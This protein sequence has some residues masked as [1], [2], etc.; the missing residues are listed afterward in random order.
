MGSGRRLIAALLA[1]A[2]AAATHAR[3]PQMR[4]QYAEPVTLAAGT[5]AI[6]FDAYGRRFNLELIN[7]DRVTS[8]LPAQRKARLSG[9]R[10]LRGALPDQPGSWVRLTAYAGR[11][12]GAI[13]DGKDFYVVTTLGGIAANLTTPIAAAPEQTVV[14]RLS[15][16]IDAFPRGTCPVSTV[17]DGV[18]P[19]DGLSQYRGMV[20]ELA[21]RQLESAPMPLQI[22]ISLIGD[23]PFQSKYTD[24][25]FE[26]L[27]R[28]NVIDGVYAEQVGLLILPTDLRLIASAQDPFTSTDPSG[29]LGQLSTFRNQDPISRARGI[30]HLMTG[31]IL[32]GD[33]VGI[34][35]LG[36]VCSAV[37]GISL[38]ESSGNPTRDGLIMSHELGHNFGAVH[39]GTGACASAGGN[40]IM[41]PSLNFSR[42]FSQC[43]LDT[44]RPVIQTAQCVTA[45]SYGDIEID[46]TGARFVVEFDSPL[47]VPYN[48]RSTGTLPA[49]D[50]KL[51]VTA[52]PN[53]TFVTASLPS[54]CVVAGDTATCD[55][56]TIPAGEERNLSLTL[57]PATMTLSTIE[58]R[59][60]ASNNPSTHNDRQ[61]RQVEIIPNAD[62]SLTLDRSTGSVLIGGSVDFTIVV[63]SLRSHATQNTV[64]QFY[65][66]GG[67]PMQIE[68]AT[69]SGATCTHDQISARCELGALDSGVTRTITIRAKATAVGSTTMTATVSASNDPYIYND[70]ASESL[71]TRPLRDLGFKDTTPSGTMQVGMPFEYQTTLYSN[72]S[73]PVDGVRV[74][75]NL[76]M[77]SSV[78]NTLEL[79]LPGATCTK[80]NFALWRCEQGTLAAV[81]T[82]S[83]SIKGMATEIGDYR[84]YLT[85]YGSSQDVTTN[86]IA[87]STLHVRYG[88]DASVQVNDIYGVETLDGAGWF[89][90]WSN[91]LQ[92]V[93]NAVLNLELPPQVRLTRFFTTASTATCEMTDAQ[94]IRCVYLIPPQTGYQ[95]VDFYF[96][97]DSPGTFQGKAT[98]TLEGD[99]APANNIDDFTF[100]ISP[101][102]DV[103]VQAFTAPEYVFSGHEESV[104]VTV[105]AGARG[106]TGVTARVEAQ[107][108]AEIAS[109]NPSSGSCTRNEPRLFTCLLGDLA[110]GATVTLNTV[111]R[112]S[113]TFLGNSTLLVN[114]QMPGDNNSNNNSRWASFITAE[115]GDA[116]V[117]VSSPTVTA[118]AGTAFSLPTITVLRTGLVVQGKLSITLPAGASISSVSG[119]GLTCSGTSELECDLPNWGETQSLQVSLQLNVSSPLTFNSRVRVSS[120]S[121]FNHS[122]DEAGIAIT[123][124]AATPPPNDP[125]SNPPKSGG[126]GGGGRIEWPIAI[127][128][129]LLLTRRQWRRASRLD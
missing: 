36:G 42:N 67:N 28:H 83:I 107:G 23:A 89:G 45:A 71:E 121:D 74:E 26:L 125:P 73:Q 6:S 84:F 21:V 11:I 18:A 4:I 96:I 81:E 24:P 109:V 57:L 58:A 35:R 44:M 53:F 47:V 17:D 7:N 69:V 37:D 22:E 106:A 10:I 92:A 15:D 122:N 87:D 3:S 65:N 13:W 20:A 80:L 123:V 70:S 72:G 108:N 60:T 118:T 40:Y 78:V 115:P 99:E 46:E 55:F 90:V 49:Q 34:A 27:A 50:A 103:G 95:G 41:S 9:Y 32:D 14:Y 54:N 112:A 68:S 75:I 31:R 52:P 85:A 8:K 97:A 66:S 100:T 5:G 51:I 25:T 119:L 86:D 116:S 29:L 30:T 12:E 2:F 79:T 61:S 105:V 98:I 48:V 111:V 64:V 101:L 76:L 124:N 110:G 113:T 59:V 94:H 82:R 117:L 63:K 88:L 128:A 127:F 104:P 102:V 62:A 38:T 43:S 1:L 19:N 129:G 77:P 91:G 126:G 33:T 16:T 93:P 39:D 114:A 56:G 120:P